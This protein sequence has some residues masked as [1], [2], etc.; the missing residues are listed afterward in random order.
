MSISIVR[1][2]NSL[3]AGYIL[4]P[5]RYNP[6][7]RWAITKSEASKCLSEIVYLVN[8]IITPKHIILNNEKL[9]IINTGDAREGHI[10]INNNNYAASINSN[11]KTVQVGDIIISRLRPYLRQI[12]FIDNDL[13]EMNKSCMVSVSTEFFVLR[14]KDKRS[15]AFLVPFLLNDKV[16]KIF[17]N[18]VEG[19]QHPRFKEDDLLNLQVPV[20]L[21]RD[22]ASKSKTIESAISYVRDYEKCMM[23]MDGSITKQLQEIGI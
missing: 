21:I 2:I 5:E 1:S 11:K 23:K 17:S 10:S 7:R 15:L 19:S 6:N 14:A 20:S 3:D 22:S 8:D 4:T 18:S 16:Q 9:I 13:F 12:A